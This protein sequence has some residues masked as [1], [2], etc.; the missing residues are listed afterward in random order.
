MTSP[1]DGPTQ[2]FHTRL[3]A[4][5]RQ[6][7]LSLTLGAGF[8]QL[9]RWV[10]GGGFAWPSTFL[11]MGIAAVMVL[12][13]FVLMPPMA[14]RRHVWLYTTG[15]TRRRVPWSELRSVRM[16]RWYMT[17]S[18]RIDT[19]GGAALWLPRDTMQLPAFHAL[20][21]QQLGPQHPLVQVLETPLYRL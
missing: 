3:P 14:N 7:M 9:W 15:G 20:A 13:T 1:E 19:A 10:E 5:W 4:L 21:V 17:P 8:A 2:R 18:L 12:A 11:M 16:G 6:G